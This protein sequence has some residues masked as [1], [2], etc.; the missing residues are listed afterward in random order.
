MQ[1][2]GQGDLIEQ[3]TI[4][5]DLKEVKEPDVLL[6]GEQGVSKEKSM[7]NFS[8]GKKH[9]VSRNTKKVTIIEAG[10]VKDSVTQGKYGELHHYQEG[11]CE[12]F[13]S[14]PRVK[15]SHWWVSMRIT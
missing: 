5:K 14:T 9:S 6:P 13:I 1:G 11:S 12:G 10:R 2:C 4:V 15:G 7:F 8:S 3:T